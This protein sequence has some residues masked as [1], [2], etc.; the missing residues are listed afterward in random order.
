MKKKKY[1]KKSYEVSRDKLFSN[2]FFVLK[3]LYKTNK[4]LY[5]ARFLIMAV[6]TATPF[7]PIVFTRNILNAIT[8]RGDM[9]EAML[10]VLTLALSVFAA[11]ILSNLFGTFD[12]KQIAKTR[13]LANLELGRSVSKIRYED[14]E[15]P[16]TKSFV[17]LAQEDSMIYI[18]VLVCNFFSSVIKLIGLSAIVLSFEPLI[19]ILI[20]AVVTVKM[21]ID[22]KKHQRLEFYRSVWAPVNRKT[23]YILDIMREPRFAKEVRI[24]DLTEW[25]CKK[26]EEHFENEV[27]PLYKSR[28]TEDVKLNV[29]TLVTGIAQEC[30]VYLI[31]A[32]RVIFNGMSIGNFSMYMTSINSFSESVSGAFWNYF[33]LI[34][35]SRFA[36]EFR[37]CIELEKNIK[38]ETDTCKE[39]YG[40]WKKIT[41]EFIN[42]SFRY[43]GTEKLILDG[44]SLK[45]CPDEALSIVG[46]NGAGKTTFVKLLCRLYEPTSGEI[47]INGLPVNKIP[48]DKYY[49]LL[50][51]VFQDFKLFSFTAR[52]NVTL[53]TETDEDK[54]KTAVEK[55]GLSGKISSLEKGLETSVSKDFDDFG[56]EFSGGEGQKL[57]IAR[58]LYKDAPLIILDEPT[59]ALDP[60]AEY[61]IYSRFHK[62]TEGKSTVY[63]SHRLSSTRFTDK[64]AVFSEGKLAEYGNHKELMRNENGIYKKMFEMQA[65][66]YTNNIVF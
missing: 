64:I 46:I 62:L 20:A 17:G 63:I 9:K 45:I 29:F 58:T 13:Y 23:N 41:V 53:S 43:P 56:V 50:G 66:Y 8:E 2:T 36:R 32:Y 11:G 55:S 10:W 33:R 28:E 31:L 37:Y 14:L 57:A 5:L 60:I 4:T 30:I 52:E 59:S 18:L 48:L 21:I 1:D 22:K 61:E 49:E 6:Q 65:K 42:V 35:M 47:L 7:I 15:H 12:Q 51:V 44:L 16:D 40:E 19:I 26:H 39:N 3:Y 38:K 34:I 27:Y 54:L 24:N 25:L